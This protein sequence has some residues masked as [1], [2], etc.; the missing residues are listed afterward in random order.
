MANAL[1]TS[2]DLLGHDANLNPDLLEPVA[3]PVDVFPAANGHARD[4]VIELLGAVSG[5]LETER[6]HVVGGLGGIACHVVERLA[7][8][9][10]RFLGLVGYALDAANFVFD[11]T[12]IRGRT[13]CALPR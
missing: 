2:A 4:H 8:I 10:E 6:L 9:F 5:R 3:E 13:A 11:S 7:D 12:N 1:V